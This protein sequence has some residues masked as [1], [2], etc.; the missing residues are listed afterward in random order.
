M[1]ART[2]IELESH[3]TFGVVEF[4]EPDDMSLFVVRVHNASTHAIVS[5]LRTFSNVVDVAHSMER[6]SLWYAD[7]FGTKLQTCLAIVCEKKESD[8]D[9]EPEF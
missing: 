3:D 6:A 8:D 4:S 2:I 9:D 5:Y 1:Y 7:L